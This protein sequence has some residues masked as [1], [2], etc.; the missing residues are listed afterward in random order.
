MI[1]HM[2]SV[3]LFA[4]APAYDP[5]TVGGALSFDVDASPSTGVVGPRF[6]YNI[7]IPISNLGYRDKN[8]ELVIFFTSMQYR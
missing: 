6:R 5:S 3:P 1:G 4:G 2:I 7:K 8:Q